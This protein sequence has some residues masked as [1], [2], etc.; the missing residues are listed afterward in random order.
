MENFGNEI[1]FFGVKCTVDRNKTH[2]SHLRKNFRSQTNNTIKHTN[3]KYH[4]QTSNTIQKK[5]SNKIE[6][7]NFENTA[8]LPGKPLFTIFLEFFLFK[9]KV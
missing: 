5:L 3:K 7:K 9:K 2:T 4:E 1:A 6:K 8:I